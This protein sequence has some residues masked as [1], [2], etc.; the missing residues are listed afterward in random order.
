M[1]PHRRS[2]RRNPYLPRLA[3]LVSALLLLSLL[4]WSGRPATSA[5]SAPAVTLHSPAPGELHLTWPAATPAPSVY[6]IQYAPTDTPLLI[7]EATA[8]TNTLTLYELE[9]GVVYTVQVRAG[10]GPW[11]VPVLQ[12]IDDYRADP[13]TVGTIGVGAAESGYIESV[14]DADW[15]FIDLA[16]G[17]GYPI[18]VTGATAPPLAVYDATG[19]VVQQGVVWHPASAL[20]FTPATA[21]LYHLAVGGPTA[22]PGRYTLTVAEPAPPAPRRS[23]TL[24]GTEP[25][26][27]PQPRSSA[28]APAKPRGLTATASHGQV[29][30]TWNDPGDA[31]ITGYVILRRVRVNDTGGEFSVLVANTGTAALTYTDATVAASTTRIHLPHQGHQRPAARGERALALGPHR[32]AGG[33]G[34]GGGAGCRT[35]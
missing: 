17:E 31:T 6:H 33:P 10:T 1:N 5:P 11:S 27:T 9:P 25:P 30:L 20:T 19:A 8:A 28:T 2:P 22:D 16:A 14:G 35:A 18:A 26:D 7:E 4:G 34:P 23:R 13:E 3:Y 21:G 12:R 29:V 15:F 24:A 32:H